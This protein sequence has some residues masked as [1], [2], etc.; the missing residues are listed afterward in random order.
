[1]RQHYVAIKMVF[2]RQHLVAAM[3]YT[4]CKR[5]DDMTENNSEKDKEKT[6]NVL[7]IAKKVIIK[8]KDVLEGLKDK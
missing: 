2:L 7:E 4:F 3:C 8:Y 6:S 5:I 1:M